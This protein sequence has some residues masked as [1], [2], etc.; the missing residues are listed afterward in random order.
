MDRLN[1]QLNNLAGFLGVKTSYTDFKGQIITA[2]NESLVAVLKAL[3]AHLDNLEDLPSA[4]REQRQ[5]HWQK[6]IEPVIPVWENEYFRI[7]L[8][9]PLKD[10][11]NAISLFL[12]FETGE[13]KILV[14][15][16]ETYQTISSAVIEGIEYIAIRLTSSEKLPW[17]YH[18]LI[19]DLKGKIFESLI[20]SAPLKAYQLPPEDRNLWGV[21]VPLYALHSQ[22]SWGAGDFSDLD[23]LITWLSETGSNLVGILPVLPSFFDDKF[24]PGPYMPASRLFWNEFYLDINQ[25]PELNSC[26]E[27]RT[28]LESALFQN[29]ISELRSSQIVDYRQQ[30]A[31]KRE[32]LEKL[33]SGF[34]NEKSERYFDFQRFLNSHHSLNEYASFRAAGEKHGTCWHNWP[35]LMSSGEIREGDYSEE[36]KQYH[37][38][39]QWLAQDQVEKLAFKAKNNRFYL[40]LDFPVGVHPFSFDVWRERDSFTVGVN[41]GAPPDPV[42]TGGQNWNFPPLHPE[43]IRK[44][45]YR[46][47]I[48]SLRHQLK[49]A[50]ML[51]IDHVMGFHRLFCVPEGLEN[52]DGV[53]VGY[54]AEELYAILTLE[55]CRN[56]TIIVGEDLGMVPPEVRPMMDKHGIYRMFIGQYELISENKLGNIPPQSVA[57]LNTHDMFPFASFWQ[58][59][60]IP[61]R[62]KLKFIDSENARKE[63]ENR[64]EIKRALISL[65]QYKGLSNDLS[66]D[67]EETL[68]SVLIL[69]AS[70]RAFAVLVNLEDLWLEIH[71]QN[72]PGT[73]R[74]QNWSRKIHF[75]IEEFTK[76][77][78]II[79]LL[80]KINQS[81]KGSCTNL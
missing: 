34:F 18:K 20:I 5:T 1:S 26:P 78:R 70:S 64:R 37:L 6:I 66:Q 51:R 39:T 14:W 63:V 67:T 4:L 65:L 27:A 7:D 19:L 3:G 56:K 32:I 80:G 75:S 57:G 17:G 52:K 29:K 49:Q 43:N 54:N 28:I 74:S 2:S 23:S 69:L 33:T 76:S 58:E 9:F 73:L 53:Y 36:V 77:T 12:V 40:Y 31:L 42:F 10:L 61:E 55:S 50:G 62:Q 81:R 46:Y 79:D 68:K 30:L 48:K 47:F 13:E 60:D 45:H 21:F 44:N 35:G 15:K 22:K 11:P 38:F 24:G 59:K 71:P 25:I 8:R 16:Q 41:G 72:I